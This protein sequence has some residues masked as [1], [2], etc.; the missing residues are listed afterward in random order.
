M[1][2]H[3][4][5]SYCRTIVRSCFFPSFNILIFWLLPNWLPI[6][7]FFVNLSYVASK[8]QVFSNLYSAT[9]L[10]KYLHFFWNNWILAGWNQT[11]S[12]WIKTRLGE[13]K[14]NQSTFSRKSTR[15]HQFSSK[16]VSWILF[17]VTMFCKFLYLCFLCK[18]LTIFG[19]LRLFN[20]CLCPC[21]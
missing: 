4:Q 12:D 13:L 1:E 14:H 11:G 21:T 5:R 17:E 3:F 8:S 6:V 18:N 9:F 2:R 7:D 20:S 15:I 19:R 10:S 16:L